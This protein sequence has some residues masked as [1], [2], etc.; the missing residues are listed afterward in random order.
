MYLQSNWASGRSRNS[1]FTQS[2]FFSTHWLFCLFSNEKD[3][4]KILGGINRLDGERKKQP[5]L[6]VESS[7]SVDYQVKIVKG[8]YFTHQ[9]IIGRM[10]EKQG[11]GPK[12][13]GYESIRLMLGIKLLINSSRWDP[14]EQG[15]CYCSVVSGAGLCLRWPA[16]RCKCNC[17]LWERAPMIWWPARE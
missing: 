6:S 3:D 7:E 16:P 10:L 4:D 12:A 15:T 5:S 13:A 1:Q 11:C 2:M 8:T 17:A 14:L 9:I